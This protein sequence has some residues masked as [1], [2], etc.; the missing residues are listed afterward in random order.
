[1][2][3]M[4]QNLRS[5]AKVLVDPKGKNWEK[6]NGAFLVKPNLAELEEVSGK[7]W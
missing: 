7:K 1:M 4:F 3:W 5:G 2:D 6:Y